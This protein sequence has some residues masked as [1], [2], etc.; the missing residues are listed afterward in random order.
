MRNPP[1]RRCL[2]I[3]LLATCVFPTAGAVAA[4]CQGF[5]D[6]LSTNSFCPNVAWL[7]NREITL[8]CSSPTLFCPAQAVN[9]L[10]MAA[11]LNRLGNVLSPKHY[12]AS[13]S[14]ATDLAIDPGQVVCATAFLDFSGGGINRTVRGEGT[15]QFGPSTGTV[16][17]SI[18]LVSR[19]SPV[20]AW[21][22]VSGFVQTSTR[23]G[24]G[25][26]TVSLMGVSQLSAST[27][28]Q[29]GLRVSRGATSP[30]FS[31]QTGPWRCEFN[32]ALEHYIA[33]NGI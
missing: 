17:V 15:L 7:R 14:A 5:T 24:A 12:G 21:Q 11:F 10:S 28:F 19:A 20:T 27:T 6:V 33:P 4:P 8:G 30:N 29:Y 3:A 16:D 13:E 2:Q 32:V 25:T 26:G 31:D 18:G 9:R 22:P 1:F 23:A